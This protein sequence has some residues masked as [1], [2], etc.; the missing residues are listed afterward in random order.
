M[1]NLQKSLLLQALFA[2]HLVLANQFAL[3][4]DP[5]PVKLWRYN[6]VAWYQNSAEFQLAAKQAYR[7]AKSTLEEGLDDSDW[8]A[9]IPQL[10]QGGFAEKNPA[11]ILDIDETVLD[12]SAYQA[13]LV[14]DSSPEKS[15]EFDPA[16]WTAWVK[17]EQ[18]LPIPGSLDFVLHARRRGASV[19]FVTNRTED[20]KESTI[21]NL[22]KYGFPAR[23]DNVLC[24]SPQHPSDKT[25]RR[26]LIAVNHRI[27]L[28]IGDNMSDLCD[29]VKVNDQSK[30]NRVAEQRS[31]WL[32]SR[33]II[34][35]NPMYGGWEDPLKQL[36][37]P[38]QALRTQQPTS[39]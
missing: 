9:D 18:A 28:M 11:V 5:K 7:L 35:P 25:S 34:L 15:A 2:F 31:E 24:T 27:V 19:F 10:E 30:R 4:D 26:A 3:A 14:V 38:K 12:N 39:D 16:K 1:P 36:A 6:S 23:A 20:E 8:T 29:G 33:W 13:R 17:E 37:D 32:G 21:R 22:T